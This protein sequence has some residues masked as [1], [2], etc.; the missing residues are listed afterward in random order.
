[1]DTM[2]NRLTRRQVLAGALGFAGWAAVGVDG[3]ANAAGRG[4]ENSMKIGCGTVTFR[5]RPLEE[6]LERIHRAGYEY[7]ETQATGPWCPHV[8]AWKDDPEKFRALVRKIGFRAVTGLWSPNGAVIPDAKSVEGISQAVRWAKAA[9]IPVV[10]CGDGGKPANMSDEDAFKILR[11]RLGKI[12]EVAA[13]CRVYVAIEPHGT[14]SLT[15]DGLKKIMALS[16]STWLGI[17]YD[18]ANVHRATYVETVAGAY[19]WKPFGK[20]QDEVATL[21]A[22]VDRV[23]HVHVKDIVGA[24]CVALGDGKVNIPGCLRTLK[25][26]GYKGALSLETEGEFGADEGQ[27]LIERSRGYL[28][29]AMADLD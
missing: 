3:F 13:K 26:A 28:T 22:I 19:S 23:V 1:M 4:G 29:K 10:H 5:T 2:A 20:P 25:D 24:K 18:T 8:D 12:L 9:G 15:A 11:D 16:D 27:G 7:V 17:N 14:F 21:K 6:A